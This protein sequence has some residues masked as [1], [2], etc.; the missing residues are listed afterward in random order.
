MFY[1]TFNDHQTKL[2]TSSMNILLES[3]SKKLLLPTI[4]NSKPRQS[5][6]LKEENKEK[7]RRVFYNTVKENWD[8]EGM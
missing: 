7:Q 3:A 4:H 2:S 1:L 6:Y 8:M 5:K